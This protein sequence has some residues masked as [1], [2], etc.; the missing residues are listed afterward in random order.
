MVAVTA[1]CL[2]TVTVHRT[3]QSV[4]EKSSGKK[5]EEILVEKRIAKLRE[6][7]RLRRVRVK[8]LI[9]SMMTHLSY[10]FRVWLKEKALSHLKWARQFEG[11]KVSDHWLSQAE[12]NTQE[13]RTGVR[14]SQGRQD[15][16]RSPS[17]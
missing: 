2:F 6:K 14:R 7:G 13:G 16:L 10:I 9:S 12:C 3:E 1:T 4:W 15:S 17:P 8:I 11:N 5:D